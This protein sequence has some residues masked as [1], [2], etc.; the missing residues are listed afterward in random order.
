M[1]DFAVGTAFT[2]KDRVTGAFKKMSAGATKFGRTSESAF[3]R[4]SRGARGF[5]DVTK[6]ILAAGAVVKGFSILKSAVGSF[7]E[8]ASKIEDAQAAFTP[9]MGGVKRAKDLVEALNKTAATTPFQFET[10]SSASKQLLPVMNGDIKKIIKTT[11]MLGDT[12]GGNAQKL[13]SITRGF[14]KAMLKGKVDMESLN[15]IGEAGVPIFSELA[16]SMGTKVNAA[17]FKMISAGKVTTK[18][19]T[20]A[21]E[22]MTSKGGIFF[23]GMEIASETFSG[24]MSTLKDNIGLTA[25]AIGLELFP[26]L[27]KFVDKGIEFAGI[28]RTWV[29]NNKALIAQKLESFFNGMKSAIKASIPVLKAIVFLLPIVIKAFIAWKVVMFTIM[30]TQKAMIAIGWIKYLWMMRGAIQ[31][32]TLALIMQKKA[33]ILSKAVMIASKVA[34]VAWNAVTLI[35]TAATWAFGAAVAFLTSPITLIILGIAALVVGIVL[36][37]KNWKKVSKVLGTGMKKVG[38]FFMRG[39]SAIGELVGNIWDKVTDALATGASYVGE[40]FKKTF[41]TIADVILTTFGNVAKAILTISARVGSALGVDVSGLDKII[42][43]IGQLQTKVRR[44]SLF[45]VEAEKGT[46]APNARQVKAI[47]EG[48]FQADINIGPLPKGTTTKEK[49]KGTPFVNLQLL[50]ANP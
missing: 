47:Q 14:T 19:L 2:S 26:H 6:G 49:K 36:L 34:M 28:I 18:D 48:R 27:K 31:K 17:F 38:K 42:N 39:F 24:K 44:E 3:K 41:F 29:K 30:A 7:I 46:E 32:A 13:D 8:E 15:M 25:G 10:L 20:G 37:I 9:L 50:G 16:Q 12:A 35:A 11:R 1:P 33:M 22:K 4:A 21:F 5:M 40:F 23:R 45:G 43:K